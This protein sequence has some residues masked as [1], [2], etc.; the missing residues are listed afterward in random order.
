MSIG[1]VDLLLM[2]TAGAATVVAE[3]PPAAVEDK[4]RHRVLRP[5][6]CLAVDGVARVSLQ[7]EILGHPRV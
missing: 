7:G 5:G 1:L 3:G 4:D 6:V 2:S